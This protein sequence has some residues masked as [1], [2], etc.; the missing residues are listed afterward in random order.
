MTLLIFHLVLSTTFALLAV[1][2]NPTW[3]PSIYPYPK[4]HT[5]NETYTYASAKKG[6]NV[7]ILDSYNWLEADLHTDTDVIKFINDQT[8]LTEIYLKKCTEKEVIKSSITSAF[9]YDN[10]DNLIFVDGIV[11]PYY[12]YSLKRANEN[13]PTW[14]VC[15][16]E[17]L[18]TARKNNLATPPGKRFLDENL[19]SENGTANMKDWYNSPDGKYFAYL[20]SESNSDFGTWYIRQIDTPLVKA[21]SFPPGGEG[22]LPNDVLPNSYGSFKWSKDSTGAFYVHATDDGSIVSY[23]RL[24]ISS[25]DDTTIIQ[26]DGS[27]NSWSLILSTDGTW[28][29]LKGV[30]DVLGQSKVY[31]TYLP[32][33]TLSDKMKWISV[34][35]SYDFTVDPI[36]VVNKWL[37]FGTSR[38]ALNGKIAKAK[39]DWSKARETNNV[40]TLTDRLDFVDVVPTQESATL[41]SDVALSKDLA[42]IIYIKMARYVVQILELETGKFL[43]TAIPNDP[44][45][46]TSITT[47]LNGTSVTIGV[48]GTTSPRSLYDVRWTGSSF[49]DV[50]LTVQKINGTDP[51]DYI[52]EQLFATSMDGTQ[53]PYSIV[54]KNGTPKNGNCTA[55]VHAY[56]NYG[57]IETFFFSPT[58]FSWLVGYECTFFVWA[59][60]RGGG[61]LGE[62][63]H[64]A[65][66]LHNKTKTIEDVVAI[67]Q[68]LVIRKIVGK[69]QIIAEGISAG[70]MVVAA[71]ANKAPEGTLGVVIPKRAVLDYFLRVR[72]PG[73]TGQFGEFGDPNNPRD[74]DTIIDWSPLHNIN[75]TKDYPTILV[76]PGDSDDR[77]IAAHSFKFL[78]QIQADRP[79]NTNP[80]LMHL[81]KSAGHTTAGLSTQNAINEGLHQLCVI[82]LTLQQKSIS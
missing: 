25:E 3:N 57:K 50:L 77:V 17:E 28:L 64:I 22:H 16:P 78:A 49:E 31:A 65:G 53:V 15:T 75:K 52:T 63:W 13:R 47:A 82:S 60:V 32:G 45:Q 73:G 18:E 46:V 23:H 62:E 33:Q 66:Q 43:H 14:Y 20:V 26:P 1:N 54:Y 5:V 69:G 19:L 29:V 39:L 59:S 21:T 48:S 51:K 67:A 34:A 10:Y 44:S 71:A 41:H 12:T 55:W 80:L 36:N 42:V 58:Y 7:T 2:A 30:K 9:N 74:F 38:N 68:D 4:A 72:S 27:E 56:G 81:V 11:N 6:G 40:N 61:D 76:I 8:N 79:N 35:P 37:Y 24:G 70:G